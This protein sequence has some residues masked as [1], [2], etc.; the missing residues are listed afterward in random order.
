MNLKKLH[1][2]RN[3]SQMLKQKFLS[4]YLPLLLCGIFSCMGTSEK[5]EIQD[6]PKQL[7]K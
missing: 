5:C 6:G 3:F 1:S 4:R 2:A 7:D